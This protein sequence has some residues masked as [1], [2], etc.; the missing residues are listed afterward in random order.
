M[1]HTDARAQESDLAHIPHSQ[2]HLHRLLLVLCAA[3]TVVLGT[4]G[5]LEYQREE[6]GDPSF[7]NA[8]YHSVQLFALHTQHFERPVPWTLE[9]GRWFGAAATFIAVFG[10]A[11]RMFHEEHTALRVSRMRGHVVVCGLGRKGWEVVRGLR[12]RGQSVVVIERI[13]QPDSI[14][15]CRNLGA[16]VITGDATNPDVLSQA[17]VGHAQSLIALCPDDGTNCEVAALAC[18]LRQGPKCAT[19][20]LRCQVHLS[21]ADFRARLQEAVE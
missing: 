14:E 16:Y 19:S 10:V 3:A 17:R 11:R 15:A 6:R 1:N 18:R 9:C 21:D 5:F 13:P 8:L 12:R 4:I 2:R 20:P 7:R